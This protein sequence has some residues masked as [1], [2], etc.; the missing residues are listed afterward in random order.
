MLKRKKVTKVTEKEQPLVTEEPIEIV[1]PRESDKTYFEQLPEKTQILIKSVSEAHMQPSSDVVAELIADL[2]E[3]VTDK[4]AIVVVDKT[5]ENIFI[6]QDT[7]YALTLIKKLEKS[8]NITY[9]V[10]IDKNKKIKYYGQDEY[11][12]EYVKLFEGIR[13]YMVDNEYYSKEELAKLKGMYYFENIYT[14][15]DII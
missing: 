15:V 14:D 7:E 3:S 4:L 10:A 12:Q 2:E 8:L 6:F 9:F 13:D 11:K 5:L 1:K